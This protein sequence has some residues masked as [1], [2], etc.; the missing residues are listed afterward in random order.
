MKCLIPCSLL[1]LVLSSPASFAG[2]TDRWLHVTVNE[3][4]A[5]GEQVSI[6]LPLQLVESLLPL[7]HDGDLRDGKVKLSFHDAQEVDFPAVW[8]VM[9]AAPDGQYVTV[10]SEDEHV[11]VKKEGGYLCVTAEDEEEKVNVRVRLAVADALFS[12]EPDEVD[13]LAALRA[14]GQEQEC[15]LVTVDGEDETVRIWIDGAQSTD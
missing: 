8:K 10:D 7:I 2:P 6:N 9:Q 5:D 3:Q 13:L 12:G 15:E 4:G 11:R 1:V 14:L